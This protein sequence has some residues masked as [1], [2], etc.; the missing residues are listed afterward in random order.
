MIGRRHVVIGLGLM[1]SKAPA[2]V[3]AQ[4]RMPHIIIA[5]LR[6]PGPEEGFSGVR[7]MMEAL[8]TL[9]WIEGRSARVEV[10]SAEGRTERLAAVAQEAVRRR[11]DVIVANGAAVTGALAAET[12]EVP[13]VMSAS[14]FDPVE[15]G[16]AESYSRPRGNITGM[17]FAADDAADK[18]IAFLKEAAPGIRKLGVLRNGANPLNL[19]VVRRIEQAASAADL[20]MTIAPTTVAA[21]VPGAVATL[22]ANGADALIAIVD[23]VMDGLRADVA[24]AATLAGMPTLAQLSF[25][26]Q[27]G[28]LLTYAADLS[29]LHRRGAAFVDRILRGSR[30]GDLPIERPTKFGLTINLRTARTLGLSIS[31]LLLAQADEVIE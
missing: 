25:Y 19:V 18:Q 16:W 24:A 1:A 15:R 13:I 30:P 8:A 4:P 11:P 27:A 3:R 20:E 10:L 7:S 28:F 5:A 12:R 29:D 17:T 22:R 23:P 9:G 6:L 21:D 31:P 2:I 26:A 14:A